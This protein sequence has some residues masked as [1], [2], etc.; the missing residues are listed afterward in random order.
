MTSNSDL[1]PMV[2]HWLMYAG[3]SLLMYTVGIII[4]ST[5]LTR[6]PK[7]A[8]FALAG[9][10]IHALSTGMSLMSFVFIRSSGWAGSQIGTLMTA[11]SLLSSLM[12]MVGFGLLFA[13]VFVSRQ[14]PEPPPELE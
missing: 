5:Q 6:Y 1:L 13:A 14:A 4:A 7:P 9:C 3:P 10:G 8:L 2:L 11:L 12:H